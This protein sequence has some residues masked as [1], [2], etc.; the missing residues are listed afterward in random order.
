MGGKESEVERECAPLATE[1]AASYA[2]K[3]PVFNKGKEAKGS[4]EGSRIK[5]RKKGTNIQ[6]GSEYVLIQLNDQQKHMATSEERWARCRA[7]RA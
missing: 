5:I 7:R 1:C 6:K 4:S 3:G 2:K